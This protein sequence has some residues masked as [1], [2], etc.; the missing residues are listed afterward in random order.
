MFDNSNPYSSPYAVANQPEATRS[1]FYKKTYA[2]LAGAIGAF[3]LLEYIFLSTPAMIGLAQTMM[4]AWWIVI[5]LAMGASWLADSWAHN[6]TSK[7]MQYAGLGLYVVVEAIIF[8]PLLLIASTYFDGIIAQAGIL[9]AALAFGISVV[10]FTTKKDFSFLGGFLKIGGFVILGLMALHFIPGI[11][12]NLGIWFSAAMVIFAA[13]AIL[14]NTSNII[15]RYSQDQYVGASLGLFA[16]IMLLF[17]YIL[18][19]LM[20]FSS[21]D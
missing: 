21:S 5:L 10:A 1:D 16:S 4:G 6:S 11:N 17:W 9:T 18:R 19:I 2:H 14:Y 3:A 7:G 20:S 8:L 15:H 12:L 13:V